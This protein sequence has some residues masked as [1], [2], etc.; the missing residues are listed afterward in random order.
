MFADFIFPSTA[1]YR[2]DES[3]CMCVLFPL[4]S[5][6]QFAQADVYICSSCASS[7]KYPFFRTVTCLLSGIG[8]QCK[9]K[10][11]LGQIKV[12]K[13][14]SLTALFQNWQC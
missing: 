10:S 1:I 9:K 14:L 11:I 13:F 3:V 4:S 2:K 12:T 5:A 7:G 8:P 6:V